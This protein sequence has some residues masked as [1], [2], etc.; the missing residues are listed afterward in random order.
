MRAVSSMAASA[1]ERLAR[2][3]WYIAP[4]KLITLALLLSPDGRIR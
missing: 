2:Q 1:D 3:L 4:M